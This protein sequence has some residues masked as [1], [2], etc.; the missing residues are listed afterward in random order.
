MGNSSVA[1]R[2]MREARCKLVGGSCCVAHTAG[3]GVKVQ[4]EMKPMHVEFMASPSMH[5]T[6]AFPS[7]CLSTPQQSLPPT[8][9]S[10][11]SINCAA[12]MRDEG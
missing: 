9:H 4:R 6:P 3:N 7:L 11:C 5:R 10:P 12:V 2:G 1:P 8:L